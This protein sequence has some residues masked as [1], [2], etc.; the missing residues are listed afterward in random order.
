MQGAT[1]HP[2]QTPAAPIAAKSS[3]WN[4]LRDSPFRINTLQ[5]RSGPKPFGLNTLNKTGGEGLRTD[6]LVFERVPQKF[7]V[8]VDIECLHHPVFVERNRTWFDVNN[9]RHLL[10]RQPFGEQL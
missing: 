6:H 5:L 8:R 7:G 10:H 3:V 2:R 1:P 4:T 9:A